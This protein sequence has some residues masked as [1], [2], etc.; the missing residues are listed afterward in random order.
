MHQDLLKNQLSGLLQS[1][2]IQGKNPR[3]LARELKK[4]FDT[5]RY[6]A[7]RLMRTELARV[8][9]E[10][11]KQSFERNGFEEYEFIANSGCCDI[12]QGLN[13]KHFKVAKMTPGENA[14]PLHPNCR[15]S[16]AAWEDSEE[17]EAWLD[18]LDKGGTTAEWNRRG[19][20]EWEKETT[21]QTEMLRRK[22]GSN[23]QQI[24]DK[25][26]YQKLT[27][28]FLRRGGV[29]I[30]GEEAERHLDKQ[31]AH[32]SYMWGGNVAFFR[33]E[34]TV[35]DVL[36]EMYHADQDHAGAYNSYPQNEIVLRRE[37]DAQEYLLSVVE[38]Y[39]IPIEETE[40]TRRNLEQYRKD[41]E[42]II[43]AGG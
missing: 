38:K 33:D 28:D 6:N 17:Y 31:G 22:L 20:A 2:M 36:E 15:C 14:A 42:D 30:R 29:I 26:T 3:V 12:C 37:I 40:V 27:R 10:A 13:G 25:P 16:V 18:Y 34:A 23:G 8:Q 43:K 9:T 24:I 7:E 4:A 41:L 1:G 39:K 35:S 11:Q 19:K 32:A 5:S 21:S